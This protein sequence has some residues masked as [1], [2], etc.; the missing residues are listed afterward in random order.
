MEPK[1]IHRGSFLVVIL[2][3]GLMIYPGAL[4][5]P[6]NDS[7]HSYSVANDSTEV[8]ED[9][10]EEY[11]AAPDAATPVEDL[12]EDTQQ[13]F[14]TAKDEPRTE[15]NSIPDGWQ[16]IGSVPICNEWLLYCDA[17]EEDPEFPGN[18][19]PGYT[20][21]SHGFVE[22]EGEIYLV[23]T[24]GGTDWNVQPAIEFIIRQ[25]VFLP[26]AGFLAA[27]SGTFAKRGQSQYVGYGLLLALM[28]LV[29]PYLVMST[30]LSGY[31]GIL[32]GLTYLVI[33][34]GVWEVIYREEQDEQ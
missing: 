27:T 32:A 16:S 14:K 9:F 20:Y 26:Y 28:A 12:S 1:T 4:A 3:V 17:Y 25:G 11:D 2:L 21:E 33:A 19:Y 22:Y 18:S 23:R 5:A 31:R 15:Y 6:Y 7:H 10:V 13:A 30:S 8:F 29:Y 24:S 34:V